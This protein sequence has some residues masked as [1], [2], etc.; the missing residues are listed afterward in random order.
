MYREM[1][2]ATRFADEM[3]EPSTPTRSDASAETRCAI[4]R[5]AERLFRDI[6][7]RKTTVADIAKALRMSPA[8]VYRFFESKKSINEAVAEEMLRECEAEL[9][10]IAAATALS[11]PTRVRRLIETVSR[12]TV[13]RFTADRRMHEMVEA[14][15]TE[16]WGVVHN[17][18]MRVDTIFCRVVTEGVASG[19]L[20]AADP[21]AA[22]RCAQAAI[23]RFCHPGL[24]LQCA[25]EPGPTI[26]QMCDFVLAGLGAREGV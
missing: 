21:V 23:T 7:Y 8:N 12:N 20:V 2:A 4:M 15:M 14:A 1:R 17:H 13:E 6:G 5:M 25:D 18:L 10:Q 9:E 11:A 26:D 22:A 3:P 16:S 24:I 19:E